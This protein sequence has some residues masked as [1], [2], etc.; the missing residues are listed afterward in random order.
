MYFGDP[1]TSNRRAY[2]CGHYLL[3]FANR[4]PFVLSESPPTSVPPSDCKWVILYYW[5]CTFVV[6]EGNPTNSEVSCRGTVFISLRKEFYT[7]KWALEAYRNKWQ[8]DSCRY[9][10]VFAKVLWGFGFS[11]SLSYFIFL[12]LP[13]CSHCHENSSKNGQDINWGYILVFI[14]SIQ[15]HITFLRVIYVRTIFNY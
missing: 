11:L 8:T 3:L 10:I 2:L 4:L 15:E 1:F 14:Y 6:S 9:G 7:I 5:R 13:L 12:T